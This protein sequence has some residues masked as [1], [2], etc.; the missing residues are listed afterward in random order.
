MSYEIGYR[1]EIAEQ[2]FYFDQSSGG[3]SRGT[4]R[5]IKTSTA[6]TNLILKD[7]IKY[8]LSIPSGGSIQIIE[9][10]LFTELTPPTSPG[11]PTHFITAQ[12]SVGDTAWLANS[13]NNTISYVTVC[14]I[15]VSKYGS[16][17]TLSYW[18]N[19]ET[20]ECVRT[21]S[22]FN[23]AS[24]LLFATAND[25]W[26]YLGIIAPSPTPTPSALPVDTDTTLAIEQI[27]GSGVTL[28]RGIPVSLNIAGEMVL[29]GNDIT[30]LEF[31][32]FVY[33]NSILST[34]SG[35]VLFGGTIN[36]TTSAWNDIID[37][38]G[39]LQPSKRYYLGTSGKIT[40]T[41]TVVAGTYSR[42]VGIAASD[43]ELMIRI[44]PTVKL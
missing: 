1:F 30:A 13:S 39:T 40:A 22:S 15:D 18:V 17:T 11:P 37:E 28:V 27:N 25:A 16:I 2:V 44:M 8:V 35:K 36:N 6:I 24:H 31:I 20:D 19:S 12:F 42:E 21:D 33:D 26:V 29:A 14:Q 23:V 7:S 43:T 10:S 32:G 4:V 34:E 5:H 3:F 41:P 9:T 38:G